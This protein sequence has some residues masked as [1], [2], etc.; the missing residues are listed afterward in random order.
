VTIVG[1]IQAEKLRELFDDNAYDSLG[2][3]FLASSDPQS[4]F[5]SGSSA[6]PTMSGQ[7]V[8]GT[9]ATLRLLDVD[10]CAF[11]PDDQRSGKP[12][13]TRGRFHRRVRGQGTRT[14]ARFAALLTLLEWSASPDPSPPT[15]VSESALAGATRLW[16]ELFLPHARAVF[17][18]GG[19]SPQEFAAKAAFYLLSNR[20]SLG[21]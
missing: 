4:G 9:P 18:V 3:R 16:E 6:A 19:R 21:R 7:Q 13:T 5:L 20:F 11:A 2:A 10:P 17:R 14:I 15:T 12:C 8:A 1:G